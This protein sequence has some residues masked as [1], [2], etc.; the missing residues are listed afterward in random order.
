MKCNFDRA[1]ALFVLTTSV[2]ATSFNDNEMSQV[3]EIFHSNITD[4]S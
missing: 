3:D 1:I 2:N 4:T